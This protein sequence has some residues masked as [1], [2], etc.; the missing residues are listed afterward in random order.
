MSLSLTWIVSIAL[1]REILEA[2]DHVTAVCL[3]PI[4][5]WVPPPLARN[6]ITL[7]ELPLF[8]YDFGLNKHFPEISER[9]DMVIVRA[10]ERLEG[11]QRNVWR[12]GGV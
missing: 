10:G 4:D 7:Q 3:H 9:D 12:D 8:Q 2:G 6:L 5:G 1:V 11:R